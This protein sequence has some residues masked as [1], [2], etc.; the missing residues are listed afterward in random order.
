MIFFKEYGNCVLKPCNGHVLRAVVLSL[1]IYLFLED[2]SPISM[3][4][5]FV[6]QHANDNTWWQTAQRPSQE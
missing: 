2:I 3:A 1:R 5:I 4:R 6:T